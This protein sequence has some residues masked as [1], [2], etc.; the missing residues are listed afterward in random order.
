LSPCACERERAR[1]TAP[2]KN[3]PR[4]ALATWHLRT[5]ASAGAR[6]SWLRRRRWPRA[7]RRL[8][9]KHTPRAGGSV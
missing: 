1:L 7:P 6:V 9:G 2:S 5:S 3:S 8:R 4:G